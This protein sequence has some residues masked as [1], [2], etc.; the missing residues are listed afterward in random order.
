[1]L[2]RFVLILLSGSLLVTSIVL[3]QRELSASP[4]VGTTDDNFFE[5]ALVG[6]GVD[7][8]SYRTTDEI[9]R[10]CINVVGGLYGALQ[11]TER[12][13]LA[14]INCLAKAE[15]AT[16]QMPSYALGWYAKSLF[17]YQ[18]GQIEHG[19]IA[20]VRA[21]QI[22]P[23]E[24]WIAEGRVQLAEDHFDI[25]SPAALTGHLR[26]LELL[27]RSNR[28]V[29]SIARRYVTQPAFRERITSVVEQLM[30]EDQLR[31][32]NNVRRATQTLGMVMP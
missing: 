27:A 23:H 30:P 32:L 2:S 10:R 25:L 4:L 13:E 28:G 26:D 6:D 9:L 11:P 7:P 18:L 21:Q 19:N 29:A 16:S 15:R 20:L 3:G 1:M 14:R 8:L 5:A 24:Q 31:F 12:I 22:G 17:S